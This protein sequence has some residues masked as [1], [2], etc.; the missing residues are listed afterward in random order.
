MSNKCFVYSRYTREENLNCKLTD[1][2]IANIKKDYIPYKVTMKELGKKY[3]VSQTAISYW[4]SPFVRTRHL[5]DPT[6][7][8]ENY[9]PAQISKWSKKCKDRK[10]RIYWSKRKKEEK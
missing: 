5:L 7:L 8:K 4:V 3:N 6:R 10:K 1:I 2:D 9:S